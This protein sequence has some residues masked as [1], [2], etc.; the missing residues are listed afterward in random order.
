M[1]IQNKEQ[2]KKAMT[3]FADTVNFETKNKQT[4]G[5]SRYSDLTQYLDFL[6][7]EYCK[8]LSYNNE[9]PAIK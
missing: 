7:T 1:R 5:N 6:P 2:V 8:D 4:W 3:V 9:L